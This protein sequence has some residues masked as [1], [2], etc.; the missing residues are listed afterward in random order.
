MDNSL[1]ILVLSAFTG[2]AV[3]ISSISAQANLLSKT[4]PKYSLYIAVIVACIFSIYQAKFGLKKLKFAH[5]SP[6]VFSGLICLLLSSTVM[7]SYF[8]QLSNVGFSIIWLFMALFCSDFYRWCLNELTI[9]H[10]DPALASAQL[11]YVMLLYETGSLLAAMSI[12]SGL[13][14]FETQPEKV[15]YFSLFFQVL[16]A[17]GY[18]LQFGKLSNLEVKFSRKLVSTSSLIH[19][20]SMSILPSL[21]ALAL[22][23]GMMKSTD[24]YIIR[25]AAKT[26]TPSF[27]SLQELL[28]QVYTYRGLIIIVVS[29]GL[30]KLIK[31]LRPSMFV[32]ISIYLSS[33][34]VFALYCIIFPGIYSI[35]ALSSIVRAL[36]RSLFIPSTYLLTGTFV[37]PL[38]GKLRSL[39]HVFYFAI[40]GILVATLVSFLGQILEDQFGIK[41]MLILFASF[42]LAGLFINQ[43]LKKKTEV[44]I[45]ELT[46]S[47]H[48]AT[49]ILAVYALSFLKPK[50]FLPKMIDLLNRQPKKVLRKTIIESLAYY[51]T[52]EA[53]AIILNEFKT[54]KE[55]IQIAVIDAL[56]VV[57]DYSGIQFIVN[58]ALIEEETR[59]AQVRMNAVATLRLFYGK[60]SIPL[61][62]NGLRSKEARY[63]SNSIEQLAYF[64]DRSL[65]PYFRKFSN[66]PVPRISAAAWAGLR[67][68]SDTRNEYLRGISR[69]LGSEYPS[70]IA[71]AL[72]TV[73]KYGDR[74]F[75]PEVERF[76]IS[77]LIFNSSVKSTLGWA[78]ASLRDKRGYDLFISYLNPSTSKYDMARILH[79]FAQLQRRVRFEIL[80]RM[81]SVSPTSGQRI[82]FIISTLKESHQDFHEEV[83]YVQ[84]I[85]STLSEA[86]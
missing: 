84:A 70:Q 44:G 1:S 28:A 73:G 56:K 63:V 68:F 25:L 24:D 79:L 16:I 11:S 15:I 59:T 77:P 20:V 3:N 46:Q 30:G 8:N 13:F 6:L 35:I 47:E 4:H 54:D 55:M 27:S 75:L 52:P 33:C 38:R 80:R 81:F 45:L 58:I 2:F 85:N 22:V 21:L 5:F 9:R 62:L 7:A 36:E 83:D 19:S 10:L 67:S 32:L 51:S 71:S 18:L 40:A 17:A 61:L 14:G 31:S 60:K 34:M 41:V 48:K 39:Q 86:A 50:S 12:F 49:S 66:S 26:F 72:Y 78:L 76:L 65:I 23:A 37:P 69:Q 64:R 42:S 29:L 82:E 53:V 43:F 57:R 74:Y